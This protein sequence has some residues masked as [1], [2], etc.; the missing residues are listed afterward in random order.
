M[1]TVLRPALAIICEREEGKFSFNP[2]N[3]EDRRRGGRK[4][5]AKEGGRGR[6]RHTFVTA[7]SPSDL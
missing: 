3:D 2:S 6:C 5:K 4:R 1:V 7:H